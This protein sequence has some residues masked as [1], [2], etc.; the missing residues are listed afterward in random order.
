MIDQMVYPPVPSDYSDYKLPDRMWV[1][2]TTLSITPSPNKDHKS[3]D[4]T[5]PEVSSALSPGR[6]ANIPSGSKAQYCNAQLSNTPTY[7][8]NTATAGGPQSLPSGGN[9]DGSESSTKF[10]SLS[11]QKYSRQRST[12]H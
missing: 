6:Y 10:E 3:D 7:S 8:T 5:H 4:K 1:P 9:S 2:P 12:H 11:Y